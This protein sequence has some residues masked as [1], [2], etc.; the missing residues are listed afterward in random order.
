[1]KWL[2]LVVFEIFPKIAFWPLNLGL[3][4]YVMAPNES[5]NLVSHMSIIEM[6]SPSL[7]V[8]KVFA[9]IRFWPLDLGRRSKV[10]APNESS[11]M[12]SYVYNRNEVSISRRFRD[13]CE[14]NILTSWPW[15]KVKG[16]GTK[17]KAIH[18]FLHDC[19]KNGVSYSRCSWDSW[20]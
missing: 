20:E 18:G 3:K 12:V 13:I 9:K 8:F 11:Y 7:A 14:N 16:H 15:T 6:M 4:S 19:D 1:M 5:P 10:M 2:S 17:W